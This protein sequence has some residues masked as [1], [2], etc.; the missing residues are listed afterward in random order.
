MRNSLERFFKIVKSINIIGWFINFLGLV[1]IGVFSFRAIADI[2]A[3]GL[4]RSFFLVLWATF[5]ASLLWR[6]SYKEAKIH[7]EGYSDNIYKAI[8]EKFVYGGAEWVLLSIGVVIIT[9]MGAMIIMGP[10]VPSLSSG[11]P[12]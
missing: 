1:M 4:I 6:M 12:R 3:L 2:G 10:I 8:I 11:F 9:G 7:L 5:G